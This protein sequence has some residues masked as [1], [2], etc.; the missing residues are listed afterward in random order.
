[1]YCSSTASK[2][3]WTPCGASV[4]IRFSST[5]DLTMDEARAGSLGRVSHMRRIVTARAGSGKAW[6]R[7]TFG[8]IGIARRSGPQPD[9]AV[10]GFP[11][12]LL[13]RFVVGAAGLVG[14]L[15]LRIQQ[16]D[17]AQHVHDG[18]EVAGAGRGEL[19]DV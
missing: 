9:A 1:M 6:A 16:L 14:L 12:A 17:L 7:L 4:S 18:A 3:A 13:V 19:H 2:S 15:R 5:S 10:H 8:R 11:L